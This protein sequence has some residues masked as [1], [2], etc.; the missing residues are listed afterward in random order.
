VSDTHIP[1]GRPDDVGD[2][3]G[4]SPPGPHDAS[5]IGSYRTFVA[6]VPALC[7]VIRALPVVGAPSAAAFVF[8]IRAHVLTG[9]VLLGKSL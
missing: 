1:G 4:M 2:S 5:R 8:S 7:R 6:E 3:L 9:N